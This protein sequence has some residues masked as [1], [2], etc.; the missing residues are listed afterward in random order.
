LRRFK[1]RFDGDNLGLGLVFRGS[2]GFGGRGGPPGGDQVVGDRLVALVDGLGNGR[3]RVGL[4]WDARVY[5]IL[6]ICR[7]QVPFAEVTLRE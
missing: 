2:G 3:N 7:R 5:R 1:G 4:S 6:R